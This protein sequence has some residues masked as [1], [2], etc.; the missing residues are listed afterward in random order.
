MGFPSGGCSNGL[1]STSTIT[2]SLSSETRAAVAAVAG[3]RKQMR[4]NASTR[5]HPDDLT[6]FNLQS[7]HHSNKG[8]LAD[9][10]PL[11]KLGS[12]ATSSQQC[13]SNEL[14]F[15]MPRLASPAIPNMHSIG[16]LSSLHLMQNFSGTNDLISGG[17]RSG[18]IT[19][20]HTET[21]SSSELSG[22][23]KRRNPLSC[24]AANGGKYPKQSENSNN[25]NNNNNNKTNNN[26]ATG[27]PND[28]IQDL[29]IH[30]PHENRLRYPTDDFETVDLALNGLP[31]KPTLREFLTV[32]PRPNQSMFSDDFSEYPNVESPS[33]SASTGSYKDVEDKIKIEPLT[34]CQ[35]D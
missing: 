31:F 11:P 16:G 35:G 24:H 2:D 13:N 27:S 34:E 18:T 7:H 20:T 3:L 26:E 4:L 14:G 22:F 32:S 23:Q 1:G 28:I 9:V 6:N 30:S 29:R 8:G 12:P 17:R 15:P 19:P 25:N 21:K 10:I 5:H 33:R